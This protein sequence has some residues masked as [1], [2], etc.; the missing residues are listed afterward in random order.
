MASGSADTP[1]GDPGGAKWLV[2][3]VPAV[4]V[5]LV[6]GA[7]VAS[8]ILTGEPDKAAGKDGKGGTADAGK[9]LTTPLRPRRDPLPNRPAKLS[10]G[11]APGDPDPGLQDLGGGL[12]YRD[13]KVG[14]GEECPEGATV[15]PVMDYVGWLPNGTLFDTSFQTGRSALGMSLGELIQGWQR[16]VPGMKVGGIRKLVIPPELGYG[17]VDKGIIPPNS[18]L[19]FEMEL[20]GLK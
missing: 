12:K 13:L 1:G 6:V 9:R 4:G 5:A 3:V 20:L 7:L 19:V 11:T 14:D 16:G 18:T 8:T 17:A 2:V 15:T 10:D